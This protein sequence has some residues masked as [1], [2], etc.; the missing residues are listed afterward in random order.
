MSGAWGGACQ[1]QTVRFGSLTISNLRTTTFN[2]LSR[3]QLLQKQQYVSILKQ[4]TL[5]FRKQPPGS[6]TVDG[7]LTT[8]PTVPSPPTK[9]TTSPKHE[10]SNISPPTN[11]CNIDAREQPSNADN[12]ALSQGVNK[13]TKRPLDQ[14]ESSEMGAPQAKVRKIDSD[15]SSERLDSQPAKPRD[16]RWDD[17]ISDLITNF[18]SYNTLGSFIYDEICKTLDQPDECVD[19]QWKLLRLKTPSTPIFILVNIERRTFSLFNS[20]N[21]DPLASYIS[22]IANVLARLFKS[23]TVGGV[24][25]SDWKHLHQRLSHQPSGSANATMVLLVLAHII[26]SSGTLPWI[27]ST[28]QI[29]LKLFMR[30]GPNVDWVGSLSLL[31][32]DYVEPKQLMAHHRTLVQELVDLRLGV[33]STLTPP[34][35]LP[36]SHSLGK[37]IGDICKEHETKAKEKAQH[38][39]DAAD[40]LHAVIPAVSSLEKHQTM[41]LG[42]LSTL[43]AQL[44]K[45]HTD[46]KGI[47]RHIDR[48]IRSS[49]D[50]ALQGYRSI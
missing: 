2:R 10:P 39:L 33:Q 30:G 21:L 19:R 31:D 5:K 11:M 42:H 49:T 29:I 25:S 28:W 41:S 1:H 43:L 8:D 9:A 38:L 23:H 24:R 46:E 16:A 3:T 34:S 27:S 6:Q 13:T 44:E 50:R 32:E 40:R 37:M 26:D 12:T 35:P 15:N 36:P 18:L 4:R 22:T 14:D 47:A 48:D 45:I 20:A 7:I 17:L